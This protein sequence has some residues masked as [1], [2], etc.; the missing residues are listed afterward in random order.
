M[1]EEK[2]MKHWLK[3]K[4]TFTQAL[5]V[6]FLTTG[7]IGY[8]DAMIVDKGEST[9]TENTIENNGLSGILVGKKSKITRLHGV[10]VETNNEVDAIDGNEIFGN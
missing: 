5:L 7:G 6:A 4:V 3:R 2:S 10:L 1:K 9:S 8:A